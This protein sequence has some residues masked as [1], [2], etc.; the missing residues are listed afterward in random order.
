[1]TSV[2]RDESLLMLEGRG[3]ILDAARIVTRVLADSAT[4]GAVIG[5]VAVTLHGH[6]RATS[7]VNVYV[8]EPLAA[9]AEPLRSAGCVFD[10]ARREFSLG[11]VPVHLV[12]SVLA[13][14]LPTHFIT[15]KD[16]RTVSLAD[17]LNLKLRSGTR[18]LLRAQDSA[19][20]IGLIRH[21][22]LDGRFTPRIA[23]PLRDDFRRLVR[24][25]QADRGRPPP[26]DPF[27][28]SG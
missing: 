8:P 1:M 4:E 25:V 10:A 17:L 5:G 24:S 26:A 18:S 12:S 9:F 13:Q 14:P 19:D 28:H 3:A 27:S 20:V 21:N 16:V 2:L 7:D 23:K 6:V 11:G 22:R 15:L